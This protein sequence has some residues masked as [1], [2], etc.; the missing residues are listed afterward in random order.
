MRKSHTSKPMNLSTK[1][2]EGIYLWLM[3]LGA[4]VGCHQRP[5][6]SF[7]WHG[8]Q[9]P[10]CA[11]C[12]GVLAGYIVALP[13]FLMVGGSLRISI[14]LMCVMFLDWL[15]QF[16]GMKESTNIRRFFT[17]ISGGYGIMTVELL[18]IAGITNRL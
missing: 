15:I 1:N 17:G 16:L 5:D 13:T 6:R 7:F 11:R 2:S 10:I 14:F 8:K 4:G 3:R 18:V 9:F 12:T